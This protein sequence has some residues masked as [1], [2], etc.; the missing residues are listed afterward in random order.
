VTSLEEDSGTLL[1]TR[2]ETLVMTEVAVVTE[3]ELVEGED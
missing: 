1:R 2:M 3:V